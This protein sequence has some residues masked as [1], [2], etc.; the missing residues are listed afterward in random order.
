MLFKVLTQRVKLH[1]TYVA[2]NYCFPESLSNGVSRARTVE[3]QP[4]VAFLSL[5]ELLSVNHG[6]LLFLDA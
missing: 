1:L 2:R 6:F 3:T 5:V 4:S